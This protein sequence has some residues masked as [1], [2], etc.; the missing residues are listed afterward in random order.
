MDY[1]RIYDGVGLKSS[2]GKFEDVFHPL[3]ANLHSFPEMSTWEEVIA[4]F[5]HQM[6][7][8]DK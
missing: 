5:K 6:T 3:T 7:W 2:L 8:I 4:D 1:R